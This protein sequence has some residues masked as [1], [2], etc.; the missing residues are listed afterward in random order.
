MTAM[1]TRPLEPFQMNPFNDFKRNSLKGENASSYS[2]R[3]ENYNG[4]NLRPYTA[5]TTFD[6]YRPP[7]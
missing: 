7:V 5:S 3:G 4:A 6:V 1:G 2:S